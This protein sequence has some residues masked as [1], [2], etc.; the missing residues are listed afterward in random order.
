MVWKKRKVTLNL[1]WLLRYE[2]Q[3]SV[4]VGRVGICL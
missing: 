3:A 1:I 4:T 2:K